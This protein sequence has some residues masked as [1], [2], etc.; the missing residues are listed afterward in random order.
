[1]RAVGKN[2][3]FEEA[4]GDEEG[5]VDARHQVEGQFAYLFFQAAFVVSADL[6][7][8]YNAVFGQAV[9][10]LGQG[11]VRWQLRLVK[12]RSDSRRYDGGAIF[13]AH[14]VL[15]YQHGAHPALLAADDGTEVRIIKFAAFHRIHDLIIVNISAIYPMHYMTS[16]SIW[17]KDM[18]L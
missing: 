17:V 10:V 2:L 11:N 1:M 6:F 8:Q 14:V 13:V 9:G 7:K 4:E 12:L 15:H 5:F 3:G 18:N 16:P